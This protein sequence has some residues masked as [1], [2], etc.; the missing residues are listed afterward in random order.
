[1]TEEV[2]P[3]EKPATVPT[4]GPVPP[5]PVEAAPR[6]KPA[7]K[8]SAGKPVAPRIKLQ[9]STSSTRSSK[10]SAMTTTPVFELP[11][12]FKTFFADFQEKAKSAYEKSTA[13]LGEYNEFTKGNVEAVVESS[14]ILASGL[15]ALGTALAA[16][17]KQAFETLTAEAKELATIKSPTD[18]FKLQGE[19]AKK[20]FDSAVAFSSKQ[21][22]AMLKLA[23]EVAAPLSSRVSIAV[24]AV[25]KAA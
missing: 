9:G 18:L 13:S 8:A 5:Q 24:E 3:Q 19:L 16:D 10:E 21:T 6:A 4:A 25:K 17:S 15:Q 22:E 11:E 7:A 1:M 2:E 20:H 12:A 14:K 23:G